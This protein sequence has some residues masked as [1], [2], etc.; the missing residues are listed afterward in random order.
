VVSLPLIFRIVTDGPEGNKYV[1]PQEKDYIQKNSGQVDI[2]TN[3]TSKGS[4]TDVIKTP[5]IWM[6]S[7]S[8]IAYL[9]IW[10]GIMTWLPSFLIES[11][12]YSVQSVGWVAAL[13]YA[14]A[15]VLIILGGY[16]SD[17][18]SKRAIFCC[19]GLAGAALCLFFITVTQSKWACAI[20][21]A[22]A[23]AL[24]QFY[25]A[26]LWALLQSIL[27][28][29]LVGTGSGFISGLSNLV[30]AASPFIMG[31]LIHFTSTYSSGLIYLI[32]LGSVGA[33]CNLVLA[34]QGY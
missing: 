7:I 31:I 26:P 20:F 1:S 4:L 3:G 16:V 2:P 24:T 11:C 28:N 27:P 21:M 15:I 19:I 5:G 6:L 29:E 18:K 23:V 25:Y 33:L 17:R 22:G 32:I 13:P 34:R 8:Y 9:S 12:G 30:A 10:W 14:L